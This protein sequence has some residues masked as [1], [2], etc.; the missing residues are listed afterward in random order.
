L[1]GYVE[2]NGRSI[3]GIYDKI[4]GG[5]LVLLLLWVGTQT[6]LNSVLLAKVSTGFETY[7]ALYI[8]EG[9][10]IDKKLS[11]FRFALTRHNEKKHD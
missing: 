4:V 9:L 8:R 11:E 2:P 5:V 1:K 10:R 7:K 6:H 3:L